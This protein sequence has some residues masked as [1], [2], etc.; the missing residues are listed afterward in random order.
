MDKHVGR[1]QRKQKRLAPIFLFGPKP[2]STPRP[3]RLLLTLSGSQK[4]HGLASAS[5]HRIP[6]GLLDEPQMLM[7]RQLPCLD[8]AGWQCLHLSLWTA[9]KMMLLRQCSWM[10]HETVLPRAPFFSCSVHLPE[11]RLCPASNCLRLNPPTFPWHTHIPT[12]APA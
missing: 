7:R 9:S 3:E 1:E 6:G 5:I 12:P 8:S 11:V 10:A 2:S 4:E